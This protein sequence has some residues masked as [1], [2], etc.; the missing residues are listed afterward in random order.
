[1]FDKIMRVILAALIEA[2]NSILLDAHS[3]LQGD[4]GKEV[5]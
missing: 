1:M 5:E 4:Q 3:H 2:M